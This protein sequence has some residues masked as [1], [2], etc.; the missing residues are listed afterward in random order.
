MAEAAGAAEPIGTQVPFGFGDT[1][2]H[3]LPLTDYSPLRR[4]LAGDSAP[5]SG[6]PLI[7]GLFWLWRR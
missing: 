3:W 7:V 2:F 6:C 1:G 4:A 5:S